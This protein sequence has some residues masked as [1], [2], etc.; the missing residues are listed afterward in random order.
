VVGFANSAPFD[1]YALLYIG[2]RE[3]G[4]IEE[5]VNFDS[6]QKTLTERLKAAYPPITYLT[7]VLV[8]NGKQF[9]C[10][11]VPGSPERPHFAGPAYVRQGSQTVNATPREFEQLIAQRNS[12]T[13]RIL[14]LQ[15]KIIQVVLLATSR[16]IPIVGRVK[17]MPAWEVVG[18]SQ[19]TAIFRDSYGHTHSIALERIQILDD[20]T[21]T[22]SMRLEIRAE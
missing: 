18:C 14:Q 16:E 4:S 17:S 19:F 6:V 8:E 12:K 2:V 13:Y 10:V 11:L 1:R 3:D 15:G 21:S 22:S 9:L 20:P 7:R 5:T